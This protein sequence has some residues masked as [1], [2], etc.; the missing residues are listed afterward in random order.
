MAKQLTNDQLAHALRSN[1]LAHTRYM[2]AKTTGRQWR[3]A[4]HQPLI[5][6]A[7]QRCVTGQTKRLIIN[8]PPRAGKTDLAVKHFIAW[9]MGLVPHSQFIHASYSKRLATANAYNVRAIM[10]HE[11]YSALWGDVSLMGDS[12]AK[13]EFRTTAGGVVYATGAGGTITGYGAGGMGAGFEGAIIID[14]PSKADEAL[15]DTMRK[16]VIDWFQNTMESRKNSPHTPIIIIMQRLHEEDLAGWLLAGGNG[17]EWEHLVIPAVNETGESFWEE[18]FPIDMLHRLESANPYVF[19]GQYMQEPT[20][21][22]GGD[23]QVGLIEIVDALPADLSFVRGW[24]LAAT[25]KKTSDYTATVKMAEK[26]GI[27]WIAHA[28]HFKGSPDVVEKT[29]LQHAQADRQTRTSIPQDPGQAGVAQKQAISKILRGHRFEFSTESG[30]K[31]VRASPL[32]SQVN[33]GNVRMLRGNWNQMLLDEMRT[34]PLGKNDDLIDAAS[35][36]YNALIMSRNSQPTIVASY[37]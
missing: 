32:A 35:R 21:A 2:H 1:L 15:S 23:F 20:P 37:R 28:D 16:N 4:P 30:D 14:D 25:T 34:F 11:A 24:D 9:A 29:I 8:M 18:Q 26:D 36:A 3:N 22:G 12:K 31:R 33:V 6:N 17:E 27:I 19:S 5:A 7:L 13:D 10:Q